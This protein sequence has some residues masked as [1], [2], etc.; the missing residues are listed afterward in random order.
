MCLLKVDLSMLCQASLNSW[1]WRVVACP[2]IFVC[3]QLKVCS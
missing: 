3:D 2:S 1:A